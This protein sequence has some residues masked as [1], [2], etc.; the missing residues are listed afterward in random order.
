MKEIEK[1]DIKLYK[2]EF[3]ILDYL[4]ERLDFSVFENEVYCKSHFFKTI[5]W[6]IE[7]LKEKNGSLG[8]KETMQRFIDDI[9]KYEDDAERFKFSDSY[10][11]QLE[12]EWYETH[13]GYESNAKILKILQS[14][15][16]DIINSNFTRNDKGKIRSSFVG[17]AQ[18]AIPQWYWTWLAFAGHE[19]GKEMVA[20]NQQHFI[21][22]LRNGMNKENK[23]EDD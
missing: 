10:F 9:L 18:D 4:Y 14:F 22:A 11:V 7:S 13:P 21:N 1:V 20:A 12:L 23:K 6:Y 8:W 19:L 3:A 2:E 17:I 16:I 5:A 15:D